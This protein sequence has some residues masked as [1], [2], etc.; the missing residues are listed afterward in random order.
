MLIRIPLANSTPPFVHV[1]G[2]PDSATVIGQ[3]GTAKIIESSTKVRDPGLLAWLSILKDLDISETFVV[4]DVL[5]FWFLWNLKIKNTSWGWTQSFGTT[6]IKMTFYRLHSWR[7]RIRRKFLD[8]FKCHEW[9]VPLEW[10]HENV[11]NKIQPVPSPPKTAKANIALYK[12]DVL[13]FPHLDIDFSISRFHGSI[14]PEQRQLS[15][16]WA[17][18]NAEDARGASNGWA[19]KT[20]WF[21]GV[22]GRV[23]G[24]LDRWVD[25]WMDRWVGWWIIG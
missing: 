3:L 15:N 25:G 11:N 17:Q 19:W 23:S 20:W 21:D 12:A 4:W 13:P 8:R 5:K 9:V 6:K 10:C 22:D 14:S 18:T 1:T 16:G 24:L 2:R 7:E